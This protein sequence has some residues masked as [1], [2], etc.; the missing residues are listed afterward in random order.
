MLVSPAV[1]TLETAERL[2]V[3]WDRTKIH[4]VHSKTL[5]F[6]QHKEILK[7]LRTTLGSEWEAA[8]KAGP[9]DDVIVVGHNPGISHLAEW[10]TGEDV[11]FGTADFAVLQI[12]SSNWSEA[13][14]SESLWSL[15]KKLRNP[16]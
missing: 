5:Y 8:R 9:L 12:E 16:N 15:V 6:S 14:A 11:S 4:V 3:G 1:R 2:G 13:L 10:L 7:Y